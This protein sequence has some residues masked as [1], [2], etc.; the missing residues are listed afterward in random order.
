MAIL[1]EKECEKDDIKKI[2]EAS[3]CMKHYKTIETVKKDNVVK[4]YEFAESIH[5]ITNLEFV[6]NEEKSKSVN[7]CDQSAG[8]VETFV[9]N[10]QKEVFENKNNPKVVE[11]LQM[12]E[13]AIKSTDLN[14][15]SPNIIPTTPLKN[16]IQEEIVCIDQKRA[17]AKGSFETL[18]KD[19]FENINNPKVVEALQ[20]SK[21]VIKSTDLNPDSPKFISA[22]PFKDEIQIQ[23]ELACIDQKRAEVKESFE[24]LKNNVQVLKGAFEIAAKS[25]LGQKF[26]E[27]SLICCNYL[28]SLQITGHTLP[29][30]VTEAIKRA[31]H[32]EFFKKEK[33]NESVK[34]YDKPTGNIESVG[35]FLRRD[36]ILPLELEPRLSNVT[37]RVKSTLV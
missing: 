31:K 27:D 37:C 21:N 12:S 9:R 5:T 29:D 26:I 6:K 20:M 24:T 14:P 10:L 33:K 16:E 22:T 7:S 13:N 36:K 2:I 30:E 17:E 35:T 34:I 8:S 25:L 3:E 1:D 19:A 32:F 11:A 4:T 18:Q 28:E 23:E 15:D